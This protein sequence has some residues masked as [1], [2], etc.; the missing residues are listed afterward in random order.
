MCISINENKNIYLRE[1]IVQWVVMAL[2]RSII[3]YTVINIQINN[4]NIRDRY[5]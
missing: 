1:G 5:M 2:I 3:T 4:N